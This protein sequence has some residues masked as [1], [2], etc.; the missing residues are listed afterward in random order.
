MSPG[1][2]RPTR[3]LET[4]TVNG[5]QRE[6]C[7]LRVGYSINRGKQDA[8]YIDVTTWGDAA[9]NHHRYLKKG[10]PIHVS[11]E[12]SHERWE[13]DGQQRSKHA[14]INPEIEYLGTGDATPPP[15]APDTRSNGRTKATSGGS[16]RPANRR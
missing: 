15:P 16:R 5:E 8:N 7:R 6:V 1:T 2:W 11:G 4:V 14:I 3:E 12:L 9:V 10:S 13:S